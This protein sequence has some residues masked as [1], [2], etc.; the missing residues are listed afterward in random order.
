M[1]KSLH[2]YHQ[3]SADGRERFMIALEVEGKHCLTQCLYP[4][5]L[6]GPQAPFPS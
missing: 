1:K 4:Y 3:S 6:H 2:G 5:I